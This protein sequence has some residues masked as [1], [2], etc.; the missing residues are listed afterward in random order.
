MGDKNE[1]PNVDDIC[2]TLKE[3]IDALDHTRRIQIL[4]AMPPESLKTFEELK[5][6]T[7]ISTGS[8]H[9]HLKEMVR[10]NFI[11]KFD[12]RPAKY[13]RSEFLTYLISL[14]LQKKADSTHWHIS[15]EVTEGS[16]I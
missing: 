8:L 12:G 6:A 16:C 9:H 11:H 5:E 4:N 1:A 14:A 7:G 15:A 13:A 3:I 2:K 10:A